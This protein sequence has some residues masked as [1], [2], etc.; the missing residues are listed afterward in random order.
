MKKLIDIIQSSPLDWTGSN[1]QAFEELFGAQDG[2]YPSRAKESVKLR[3]PKMS[4]GDG[5][6]FA[7]FIHPDNPDSGAY[8]GMSFVVFPV[9]GAP[10][11]I[12]MVVGTQGL[13][14]DENIL[15]RP[16]HARKIAAICN[17]L[18]KEYGKGKLVVSHRE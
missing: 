13:S 15:S 3:A 14:P 2:R 18:N 10:C 4:T 6:S 17:W 1:Q 5:V 7:A 12:G 16:G 9:E 11:L 8:G